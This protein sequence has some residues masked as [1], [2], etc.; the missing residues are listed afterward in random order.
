[1]QVGLRNASQLTG[2]PA[3]ERVCAV[4]IDIDNVGIRS[5]VAEERRGGGEMLLVD[6]RQ[7]DASNQVL[8]FRIRSNWSCKRPNARLATYHRDEHRKANGAGGGAA[9]ATMERTVEVGR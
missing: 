5:C 7:P 6:G 1:M 2:S 8:D 3:A 9:C 4:V